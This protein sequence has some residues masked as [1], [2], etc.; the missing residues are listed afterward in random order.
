MQLSELTEEEEAY[1]FKIVFQCEGGRTYYLCTNSQSSMVAWMKALSLASYE[2][3]KLMVL[4]LQQQLE[5]AEAEA[6]TESAPTE[7]QGVKPPPRGQR[8]N[9]F[10]T[11]D[12]KTVAGSRHREY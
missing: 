7:E 11:T 8:H 6:S 2:Y 5:E 9:P 12:G 10:N 3:M 1:S 4:D